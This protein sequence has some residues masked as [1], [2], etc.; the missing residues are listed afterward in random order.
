[1]AG[2]LPLTAGLYLV[3]TPIG[4]ARDITLRALD[5]LRMADVIAAEDTRTA[6]KLMEIHGVPLNGRRLVAFHD[7]SG[8]GTVAHLVAQVQDG[9]SVAYVSEAGTPLVADPGYELSQGM[10]AAGLPVTAAPGASAVLTALTIGGLPTDRFLFNGFLPSAHAAR[11]TELAGLRDVPATLVFYESPKR[12]A[13]CLVDMMAV[14]GPNR[15]AA[16]CR[17][18]TKKFEEV[19]RGSLSE[20]AAYYGEND[21][22][23]EV[24]VL[25]D[26]AGAQETGVAD[27]EGALREAMQTMRIKDAATLVAGALNLPRREVYQIALSMAQADD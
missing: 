5:V 27:V 6:R 20:L 1:M 21:V 7:H 22:R 18:L 25:V 14:F 13:D 4:S 11:Q 24:V 12:L 10:I 26:R 8:D 19:R 15:R 3:A 2:S 17:E 9:K 23:G 16:I